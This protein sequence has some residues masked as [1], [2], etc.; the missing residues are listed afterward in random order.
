MKQIFTLL[1]STISSLSVLAY[2]G[3]RLSISSPGTSTELKIEIDGRKFS[4]KNNEITV[5]YLTEGFHQVKI[6]RDRKRGNDFRRKQDIIFNGSVRLKRGYHTDIMVNRF[7]KVMTDEHLIDV[8]DDYYEDQDDNL[9]SDNGGWS[10]AYANVMTARDFEI[11]KDQ[12]RREW[13]ETNR[14]TSMCN[15]IEKSEFTTSQVKDLMLLFTFESNRLEI[16]KNAYRKTVDKEKYFEVNDA[17]TFSS[18]KDDLA[19]FIRESR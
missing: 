17:L 18:S 14:M 7:G 4:M 16:A 15:I 9:D 3:S 6:Y 8:N 19:R 13:S 5:S 10:G 1:L 2:D 11:L 12:L